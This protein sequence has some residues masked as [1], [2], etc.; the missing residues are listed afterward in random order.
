MP[1]RKMSAT[2]DEESY[3]SQ[4]RSSFMS[5]RSSSYST[6]SI[7]D[8][9]TV[10]A[11]MEEVKVWKNLYFETMLKLKTEQNRMEMDSQDYVASC[12]LQAEVGINNVDSFAQP[13]D[14]QQNVIS[15]WLL[16]EIGIANALKAALGKI[17]LMK[18]TENAKN[19]YPIS[20][21]V[22][23]E[24]PSFGHVARTRSDSSITVFNDNDECSQHDLNTSWFQAS[25]AIQ[26]KEL[27]DESAK[28]GQ[29]YLVSSW[30]QGTVGIVNAE[31]N[32]SRIQSEQEILVSAWLQAS[33]GI[34]LSQ[35]NDTCISLK[36]EELKSDWIQA[37]AA[38]QSTKIHGL[39]TEIL[40]QYLL[41]SWLQATC[42]IEQASAAHIQQQYAQ[43]YLVQAYNQAETAIANAKELEDESLFLSINYEKI[44]VEAMKA[45][46]SKSCSTTDVLGENCSLEYL[47][48]LLLVNV[49]QW[50]LNPTSEPIK[51]S[52]VIS[53]DSA[54]LINDDTIFTRNIAEITP[55]VPTTA[56]SQEYLVS[57]WLQASLAISNHA[58][59][60]S[61]TQVEQS[62][63][64]NSWLQATSAIENA[65]FSEIEQQY[66]QEHLVLAYNQ[67][68]SAIVNAYD[69]NEDGDDLIDIAIDF[70]ELKQKAYNSLNQKPASQ[71][72]IV[73]TYPLESICYEVLV[74][75]L[76]WKYQE[77]ETPLKMSILLNGDKSFVDTNSETRD[78]AYSAK[79]SSDQESV[80]AAWTQATSAI[81]SYN[82]HKAQV[83]EQQQYL[84]NSWLQATAGVNNFEFA[85]EKSKHEQ[86]YLT[87][88]YFQA[89]SAI[90]NA[91][92]MNNEEELMNISV[93]YQ[94]IREK[95][96]YI[97]R[98]QE[99]SLENTIKQDSLEN[100]CLEVLVQILQW[101][102]QPSPAPLKLSLLIDGVT[103]RFIGDS[104]PEQPHVDQL[105]LTQAWA[106]A[107][108][109]ILKAELLE[110]SNVI[111]EKVAVIQDTHR[112]A[113]EIKSGPVPT[114][115]VEQPVALEKKL[116]DLGQKAK[117]ER[118]TRRALVDLL[119]SRV[120]ELE[121]DHEFDFE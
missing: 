14:S 35:I 40:Q 22:L 121:D 38:V 52:F 17:L 104:E 10:E 102:Y 103:G 28:Y 92:E 91:K 119:I 24:K 50:R 94:Q 23:D 44:Q 81:S 42:G 74:G 112:A 89:Q 19:E 118:K 84:I 47:C 20:R 68:E 86:E 34:S 48:Y 7:E 3:I 58:T 30:L 25:H 90:N 37:S 1:T 36:Q 101:K 46:S 93:D 57:A 117:A 77:T 13:V 113:P 15:A 60:E 59:K 12:W 16:A 8:A 71:D 65:R 97:L 115:Q 27:V 2:Y 76:Q 62:I 61:E 18:E 5:G 80:T 105:Y 95:A 11:L 21:M 79:G 75:I 100:I 78:I 120:R 39:E 55:A 96:L 66:N 53:D 43:E 67:A 83:Q 114:P 72:S 6:R 45:L 110:K 9:F 49:L 82:L 85:V 88:S 41:S 107:E 108:I 4:R 70:E 69:F 99:A 106:M 33:N 116:K 56:D 29:G 54:T 51:M 63:L 87:F 109:G 64:M 32:E 26:Q 31:K 73:A 98:Q 111:N